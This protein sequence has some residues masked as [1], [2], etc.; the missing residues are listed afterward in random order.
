MSWV[1][2]GKGCSVNYEL[3]ASFKVKKRKV[4]VGDVWFRVLPLS[5]CQLE[6]W[7]AD[8]RQPL[9]DLPRCREICLLYRFSLL[10]RSDWVFFVF[11]CGGH[12]LAEKL[13]SIISIFFKQISLIFW[14]V[15]ILYAE[16][17][18]SI[19]KKVSAPITSGGARCNHYFVWTIN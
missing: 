4:N 17:T 18:F 2:R 3:F 14:Y 6:F 13:L 15:L 11:Y 1:R 19:W 9:F 12:G 5:V 8:R 10:I 16:T 7:S